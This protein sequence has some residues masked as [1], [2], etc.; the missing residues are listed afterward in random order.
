MALDFQPATTRFAARDAP[1]AL[2]LST[3]V[4]A[5]WWW[6]CCLATFDSSGSSLCAHL[7]TCEGASTRELNEEDF[8]GAEASRSREDRARESDEQMT[9]ASLS[10]VLC[11][12]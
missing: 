11:T 7:H 1:L 5:G 8:V 4:D 10:I 6:C 9:A 2:L 12:M 3:Q